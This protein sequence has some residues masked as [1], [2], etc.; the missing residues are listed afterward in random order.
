MRGTRLLVTE[1]HAAAFAVVEAEE[2][3]REDTLTPEQAE[4]VMGTVRDTAREMR[5]EATNPR[6]RLTTAA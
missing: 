4:L 1:I 6:A 2:G 5:E 3:P